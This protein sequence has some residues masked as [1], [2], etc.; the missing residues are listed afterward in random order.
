M[1]E[2]VLMVNIHIK[3]DDEIWYAFKDYVLQK[4]GKLHGVLGIEVTRALDE[5]LKLSL[6]AHTNKNVQQILSK[7]NKRHIALLSHIV[8]FKE[9]TKSDIERYIMKNFGSDKRTRNKYI[10]FLLNGRFIKVLKP[11]YGEVIYEVN[12][13]KAL[14]FLKQTL[15]EEEFK[16]I[17]VQTEPVIENRGDTIKECGAERYPAERYPAGDSISEVREKLEGFGMFSDAKI[18]N[19]IRSAMREL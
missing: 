3:V 7:P 6:A 1:R 4:Y 15:S 17:V 5:Y 12:R 11:L 13:Q 14:D 9:I 19:L 2:G 18:R 16:A 10:Q 8:S